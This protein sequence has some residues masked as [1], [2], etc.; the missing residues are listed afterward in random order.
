VDGLDIFMGR[1]DGVELGNYWIVSID[2][3]EI[4]VGA[5]Q[6]IGDNHF[7]PS[8]SLYLLDSDHGFGIT[9]EYVLCFCLE[10]LLDIFG[11]ALNCW[12]V[13]IVGLQ[14]KLKIEIR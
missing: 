10:D 13:L 4:G 5:G 11:F 3:F 7:K 14:V 9:C 12:I 1:E 8:N 2:C 6:P